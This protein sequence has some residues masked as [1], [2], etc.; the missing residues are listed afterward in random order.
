MQ[1]YKLKTQCILVAS[2]VSYKFQRSNEDL[3]DHL[4]TIGARFM[5]LVVHAWATLNFYCI[6]HVYL[7]SLRLNTMHYLAFQHRYADA[8]QEQAY[9]RLPQLGTSELQ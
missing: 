4:Q 7:L 9:I 6:L 3:T 1:I 2:S 8:T 5:T